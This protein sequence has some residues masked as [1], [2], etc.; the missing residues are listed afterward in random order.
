MEPS[1]TPAGSQPD[2]ITQ[3]ARLLVEHVEDTLR[4]QEF[5]RE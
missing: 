4:E 2:A 1:N 5:D 3:I